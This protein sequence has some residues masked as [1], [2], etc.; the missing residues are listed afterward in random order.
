MRN[1]IWQSQQRGRDISIA[2]RVN[3]RTKPG[4]LQ[5]RMQRIIKD[6]RCRR[7]TGQL[8][9]HCHSGCPH[10]GKGLAHPHPFKP[11]VRIAGIAD[12]RHIEMVTEINQLIMRHP[13]KRPQHRHTFAKA[14]RPNAGKPAKTRPTLQTHADSFNLVIRM[15]AGQQNC[16][17]IPRNRAKQAIAF[18]T[19]PC[20]N[21]RGW[22]GCCQ[23]MNFGRNAKTGQPGAGS[24]SFTCRFRAQAMINDNRLMM[25]IVTLGMAMG[26]PVRQQGQRHAVSPT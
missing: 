4:S 9:R 14:Q 25:K 3:P 8:I 2:R 1:R 6:R 16:T 5:R 19:G 18:G 17:P 21:A 22:R 15:M 7:Q 11:A 13:Q 10:G 24:G 23:G 12:K 26:E 20:L